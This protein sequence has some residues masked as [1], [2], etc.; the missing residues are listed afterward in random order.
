MQPEIRKHFSVVFFFLMRSET[1]E[2]LPVLPGSLPGSPGCLRHVERFYDYGILHLEPTVSREADR[3]A[4][5]C[6][7][8]IKKESLKWMGKGMKTKGK[9]VLIYSLH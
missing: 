4:F 2:S 7:K 3:K 9:K 5:R 6:L 8:E 1:N